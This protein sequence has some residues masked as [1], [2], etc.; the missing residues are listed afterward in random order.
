MA[1]IAVV[2]AAGWAKARQAFVRAELVPDAIL[3]PY[4]T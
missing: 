3:P 1:A 4:E 2:I